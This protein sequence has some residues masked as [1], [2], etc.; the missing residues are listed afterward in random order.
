[1]NKVFSFLMILLWFG[2]FNA[3]SQKK[4]NQVKV[5]R[6]ATYQYADNNRI[7][8]IS[9]L[10]DFLTEKMG[11][12]VEVKSYPSV[13]AFIEAIQHNEVDIA[14]INTFGYMLLEASKETYP[15]KPFLA[16]EVAPEAVDN[17]KTAMVAPAGSLINSIEEV[18]K[19]AAQSRLLLVAE[20]ST[21]GNLVPRLA[22]TKID[23]V[24]AEKDFKTVAYGKNH[25]LTIEAVASGN[26]DL[27]AMG[28]T[29][30][31]KFIADA[32]NKS[33]IKLV[34]MSPEIPLGPVLINNALG[35]KEK[36]TICK[37][38]LDLHE[39]K[40]DAL[41]SVKNGWSEAKQAV[42]YIRIEADY[43]SP[44]EQQLGKQADL[45]M[46]LKQFAN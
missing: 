41:L 40:P 22:L 21:S 32:E 7:A 34:W 29:E 43:Y 10:A 35:T 45:Q 38:L 13:H 26:A 15:M 39:L 25:K 30:Y 24:D 11:R 19:Y 23:I 36:D 27:A 16:L 20:G 6:L 18:K 28:S 44:F 3:F 12:E 9:P 2:G 14:L 33:K 4:R 8:N 37:T 5:L 31:F 46:I 42:K 17:Y 1:M